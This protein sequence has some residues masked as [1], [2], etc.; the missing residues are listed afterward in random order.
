MGA[1]RLLM[2][3]VA[4]GLQDTE[5]ARLANGLDARRRHLAQLFGFAHPLAQL[6][7]QRD[8]ARDELVVAK[9]LTR[10][11]GVRL[12]FALLGCGWHGGSSCWALVTHIFSDSRIGAS[13]GSAEDTAK[14]EKMIVAASGSVLIMSWSNNVCPK[15][16]AAN[17]RPPHRLGTG[18]SSFRKSTRSSGA[19]ALG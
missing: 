17:A 16:A 15:W 19:I 5:Q 9:R 6:R 7:N 4:A 2:P 1:Q 13:R 14:V 10:N 3:A 18:S 12:A 11:A 8:G